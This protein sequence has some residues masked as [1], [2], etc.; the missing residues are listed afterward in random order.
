M[1]SVVLCYTYAYTTSFFLKQ[2]EQKRS[3]RLDKEHKTLVVVSPNVTQR[4]R[5]QRVFSVLQ[6][7]KEILFNYLIFVSNIE[8][9]KKILDLGAVGKFPPL[10]GIL[11]FAIDSDQQ[12]VI[13][14]VY[15]SH[16]EYK[17]FRVIEQKNM[18]AVLEMTDLIE[19]YGYTSKDV[20]LYSTDPNFSWGLPTNGFSEF[21]FLNVLSHYVLMS[22]NGD[23]IKIKL[24]S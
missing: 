4:D 7:N 12:E 18:I 17:A 8:E 3:Y 13:E 11:L 19:E 1:S 24:A 10:W 23:I 21:E 20:L 6:K 16:D 14:K 22:E 2:K 5:L 9:L 15:S